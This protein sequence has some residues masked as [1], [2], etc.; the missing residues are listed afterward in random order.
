MPHVSGRILVINPSATST[1]IGVYSEGAEG[2]AIAD[3]VGTVRHPDEEL[4]PAEVAS[5]A[6][7]EGSCFSARST[8]CPPQPLTTLPD[9]PPHHCPE[10]GTVVIQLPARSVLNEMAAE[11]AAQCLLFRGRHIVNHPAQ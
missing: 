8:Q 4:A 7:V 3:F 6:E 10:H 1:K 5:A 9:F 2:E 11:I